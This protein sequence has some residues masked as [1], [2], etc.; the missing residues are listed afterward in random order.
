MWLAI[1]AFQDLLLFRFFSV[2]YSSGFSDGLKSKPKADLTLLSIFG[3]IGQNVLDAACHLQLHFRKKVIPQK[4]NIWAL[5]RFTLCILQYNITAQSSS[6]SHFHFQL[7][8]LQPATN[9]I[10]KVRCAADVSPF[11]KWS[12]WTENRSTET[13]EA[14]EHSVVREKFKGHGTQS[15]VAFPVW[16]P[17]SI[18]ATNSNYLQL[19]QTEG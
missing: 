5:N 9:Y 19:A 7:G 16:C 3:G 15:F 4:D 17:P 13:T 18:W 1:P 12:N 11:W 6:G 8:G 2:A 10:F 14:G